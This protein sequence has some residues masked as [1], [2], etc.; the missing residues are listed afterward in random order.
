M[1]IAELMIR[2]VGYSPDT[3]VHAMIDGETFPLNDWSTNFPPQKAYPT[4]AFLISAN[5]AEGSK[6]VLLNSAEVKMVEKER[7]NG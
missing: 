1:T 7:E 5:L 4:G 6:L 3:E 2:M